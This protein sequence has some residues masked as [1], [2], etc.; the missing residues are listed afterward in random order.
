MHL[1]GCLPRV[2]EGADSDGEVEEQKKV[3]ELKVEFE[4]LPEPVKEASGEK[5]KKAA[6][7]GGLTLPCL[8]ATSR[9]G[10]PTSPR[11]KPSERRS[12]RLS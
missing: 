7:R 4:P 10:G 12:R 8:L 2:K 9:K 1:R 11:R 5:I 6:S 3:K